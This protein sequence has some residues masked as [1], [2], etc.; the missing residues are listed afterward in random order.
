MLDGVDCLEIIN[1]PTYPDAAHANDKAVHFLDEL[2][3]DG[4]RIYGVG[5]SDSHN[6][7][8]ERYE[9]ATLPSIVGD[10]GTYVFCKKLT[11]KNLM[12]NVK[13]GHI[14]VTRFIQVE[15]YIMADGK[16]YLPGDNLGEAKEI[17]YNCSN[18]RR[19]RKAEDLFDK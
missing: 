7:I 1:D 6:L 17:V 5:G 19:K 10:P 15:P 18:Q 16:P 8:E 9:G 3:N 11:P 13:K 14:C 2:W 4:Y 12:K